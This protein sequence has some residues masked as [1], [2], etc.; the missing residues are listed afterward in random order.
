MAAKKVDIMELHQGQASLKQKTWKFPF[1]YTVHKRA[2]H[3][4]EKYSYQP[5]EEVLKNKMLA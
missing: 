3:L 5:I 4:P 2:A 1:W